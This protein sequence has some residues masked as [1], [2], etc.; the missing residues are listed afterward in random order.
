[1]KENELGIVDTGSLRGFAVAEQRLRTVWD[2]GRNLFGESNFDEGWQYL[3]AW[4]VAYL[5]QDTRS[6]VVE[7]LDCPSDHTLDAS[8]EK[9]WLWLRIGGVGEESRVADALKAYFAQDDNSFDSCAYSIPTAL[10]FNN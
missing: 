2:F 3:I 7:K 5:L 9:G 4:Y 6:F 10:H 8:Y 1:M